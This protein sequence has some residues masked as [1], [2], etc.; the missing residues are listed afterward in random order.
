MTLSTAAR[1]RALSHAP[2]SPGAAEVGVKKDYHPFELGFRALG[3]HERCQPEGLTDGLVVE[4][5]PIQVAEDR[6]PIPRPVPFRSLILGP[7]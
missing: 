6:E 4:H 1:I 2:L 3:V 7:V 5:S